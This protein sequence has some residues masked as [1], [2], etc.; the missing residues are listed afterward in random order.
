VTAQPQQ[1]RRREAGQRAVAGAG[2]QLG[3]PDPLLD[4]GALLS[5]PA[6]VPQDGGADHAAG[7]V[8]RHEPVHLPAQPD[9]GDVGDAERGEHLL[10][11]VPPVLGVLLRPAGPRRRERIAGLGARDHRARLVDGERLDRRR[12]DVEADRGAHLWELIP[13]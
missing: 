13:P 10:G 2:D 7:R 11:R 12:A 5:R 1:L 3:E 8:E 9:P 6:V 4:L